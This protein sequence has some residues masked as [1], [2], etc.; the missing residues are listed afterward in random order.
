M[1][2]SQPSA[3]PVQ[4]VQAPRSG[5][6]VVFL[7]VLRLL[8]AVQM[9][10]GHSLDALLDVSLRSGRGFDAWTFLRGLTSVTFLMTAG[11]AFALV[12]C[13]GA[14]HAQGRLRRVKRGLL[15]VGIGY[16]MHAPL[17]ILFGQDAVRAWHEFLAVDVLQC[18]GVCLLT[19]EGLAALAGSR[20]RLAWFSVALAGV[21]FALGPTSEHWLPGGPDRG[22]L[23][24]LTAR[25]GSIFPLLPWGGL[26]FAGLS[27]G[28]W[29]VP[30]LKAGRIQAAALRLSLA[31]AA[32]AAL[33]R[34]SIRV[35]HVPARVAPAY[36]ALK[37]G[38][39]LLLAGLL[40]ALCEGRLRLPRRLRALSSETLFLYV[41]H[42]LVLYAGQVGL[43]RWLGRSLPLSQALLVAL[44]LLLGCAAGALGYRRV[45]HSLR[46]HGGGGTP[47][48]QP[49]LPSG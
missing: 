5:E 7:D 21:C 4:S 14:T 25:G 34:L 6:R 36:F 22:L 19:M 20:G 44:G 3:L 31:G 42:V 46:A 2:D 38:L 10:Q 45:A 1:V 32:L 29:V 43:S 30:A 27:L 16:A 35:G 41:S 23:N 49:P 40:I 37:L 33:G 39:V 24:Y 47:R 11:M 9:I 8:A 26:V 17:G 18:I 15:L 28:L 12:Q 48:A 13:A